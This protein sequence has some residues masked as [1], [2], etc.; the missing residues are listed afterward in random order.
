MPS[1]LV[2]FYS[3][4]RT[5]RKVIV[6]D[7]GF[8]GDTIHLIPALWDLKQAFQQANLQVITTPLGAEVLRLAPCVDRAW[9]VELQRQKRTLRQQ[10]QIIRA[11]RRENIELAF[12]FSGADR[13]LFM[14]AL[15]GARW[16]IGYPGARQHFWNSW[17]IPNWA[18][19]QDP[20][21]TVY[22]Q[23][24]RTLAACGVPLG[25][26][27]FDLQI[28]PAAA[29]WAANAV[30]D[31]AMHVSLNSSKT[32]REWPL[33]HHVAML[34]QVWAEQPKLQVV[35]STGANER[36]KR[37]LSAF[38]ELL[39][40]PRLQVITE[41]MMIP[42]LAALLR[43]CRL[44]LGPDSGVLHL[45]AALGLPT[46]SFFRQQGAYKSFMPIGPQHRVIV[47]PCSCTDHFD[48]P[49]EKVGRADCFARIEP[50]RVAK[51]VCEALALANP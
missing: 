31:F 2:H 36:E 1:E 17:L 20:D 48:S 26:A 39:K 47:M 5:A 18:P 21:M 7:L 16:K 23:R 13:T 28:E 27:R 30:S 24:R 40:D 8:L 10:W 4:T 44:H 35:V 37:R 46:V 12:N 29:A 42:Q 34:R 45:A 6:V 41:I 15:T 49:C 9:P 50:P 43:R 51:L 32:T 38:A 3:R 22:E 19:R 33:E 14:T 25:P 11:V